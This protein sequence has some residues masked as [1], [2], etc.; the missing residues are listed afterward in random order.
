MMLGSVAATLI[1]RAPCSVL[2]VPGSARTIAEARAQQAP[3]AR[4]RSFD[5]NAFDSELAAFTSRNIGR[6]CMV[7]IDTTDLGAQVLGHE[8]MLAG[9]SFDRHNQ[10]VTLMFGTSVLRGM[11]LSHGLPDVQ[12]IDLASNAGGEDQTLRFVHPGGQTLLTLH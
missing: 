6:R 4:T 10:S 11:H 8:L 9:A 5:R 7:E 2:A 1:R 12:A 3:N